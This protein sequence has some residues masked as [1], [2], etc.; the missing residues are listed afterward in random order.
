[1]ADDSREELDAPHALI[2][3]AAGT[4]APMRRGATTSKSGAADKRH[5]HDITGPAAGGGR[6]A[7]DFV[8]VR[9][10]RHRSRELPPHPT[11]VCS[12]GVSRVM[13][14]GSPDP[15]VGALSC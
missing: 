3:T 1:V 7:L 12:R 4:T 10:L 9:P 6:S 13:K 15:S 5:V 14:N 11:Y 8:L 2:A